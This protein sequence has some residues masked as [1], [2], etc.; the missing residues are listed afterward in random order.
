MTEDKETKLVGEVR[1][2]GLKQAVLFQHFFE[3][4]VDNPSAHVDKC[5]STKM[6]VTMKDVLF[7]RFYGCTVTAASELF[8]AMNCDGKE[9]VLMVLFYYAN[10]CT[11]KSYEVGNVECQDFG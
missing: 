5:V 2:K 9:W 7:R 3:R 6:N 8:T 11:E 1:Q 4:T 10:L